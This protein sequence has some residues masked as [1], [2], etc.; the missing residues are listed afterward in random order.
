MGSH[1]MNLL[2]LPVH[3]EVYFVMARAGRV[4]PPL[5]LAC[6]NITAIADMSLPSQC[7]H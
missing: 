7:T 2:L 3:A 5:H 1:C 4:L 6:Y